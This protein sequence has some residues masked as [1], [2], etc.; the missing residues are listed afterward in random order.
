MPCKF[1][2]SPRALTRDCARGSFRSWGFNW[3]GNR[4][5]K[6]EKNNSKSGD[7]GDTKH[8]TCTTVY[9]QGCFTSHFEFRGATWSQE[10]HTSQLEWH[11]T[12]R[13]N[14][15]PSNSFSH[16]QVSPTNT[17]QHVCPHSPRHRWPSICKS[18]LKGEPEPALRC[19]VTPQEN[20]GIDEES[21]S[22][23]LLY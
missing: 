2:I 15:S 5:T 14:C 7:C 16:V 4:P 18:V 19:T 11:T 9:F 12:R 13:R 23:T 17:G 8:R 3:K 21:Q 1:H 20:V 22:Y 6:C 10:G